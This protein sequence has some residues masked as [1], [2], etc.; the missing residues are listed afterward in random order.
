VCPA[1]CAIGIVWR[2]AAFFPRVFQATNAANVLLTGAEIKTDQAR[3]PKPT[4]VPNVGEVLAEIT[5]LGKGLVERVEV[6]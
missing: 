1:G 2:P 4:T 6:L 3:A 5:R